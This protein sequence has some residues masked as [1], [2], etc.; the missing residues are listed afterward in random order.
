MHMSRL[1]GLPKLQVA[2]LIAV[3]GVTA[4][5]AIGEALPADQVEFFEKKIRPVLVAH[6]YECH[7][8]ES[9][10]KKK[11]MRSAISLVRAP[12]AAIFQSRGGTSGWGG[13]RATGSPVWRAGG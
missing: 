11:R 13:S 8:A 7:S 10:T 4:S 5:A 3:V 12:R 6:C 2:W 9:A 1:Q